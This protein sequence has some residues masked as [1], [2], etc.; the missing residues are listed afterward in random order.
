[1]IQWGTSKKKKE[2]KKRITKKKMTKELTDN[3]VTKYDNS[4][5]SGFPV[6]WDDNFDLSLWTDSLISVIPMDYGF[7]CMLCNFEPF[8]PETHHE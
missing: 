5:S 1:M 6:S 4:E 3:G 8:I 2:K 7:H